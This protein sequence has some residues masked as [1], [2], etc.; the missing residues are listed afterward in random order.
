MLTLFLA[1]RFLSPWWWRRYIPL[2]RWFLHEPHSTTS[3]KMTFFIV[4][5][6]NTSN[7]T[8]LPGTA[9]YSPCKHDLLKTERKRKKDT[10]T[11]TCSPLL[12]LY[13]TVTQT[14]HSIT[15]NESTG[16]Y[17]LRNFC[18]F[19]VFWKSICTIQ[20]FS[21]PIF[22]PLHHFHNKAHKCT[23]MKDRHA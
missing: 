12:H 11:H 17:H 16:F 13:H 4:T 8:S 5:A 20:V 10:K 22:S 15:D 21:S 14:S 7:L 3:R 23:S 18:L 9:G 6:M 2:K 19:L 1:H